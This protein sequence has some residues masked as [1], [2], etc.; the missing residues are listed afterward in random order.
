VNPVQLFD[1]ELR[2]M[3]IV[4]EQAPVSAKNISS[5]AGK[6]FGWNK[7]TTYTVLKRLVKKEVIKRSEPGFI[8]TP[9]VTKEQV[10]IQETKSLIDKVYN[11]S[12][13]LLFSTFF[14]SEKLSAE[15]LDEIQKIIDS[16]K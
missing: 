3:E 8:C 15:D 9:L 2:L 14:K 16:H 12:A 10:Q 1:S 5:I 4:W 13:K 11:G 7:N 6:R